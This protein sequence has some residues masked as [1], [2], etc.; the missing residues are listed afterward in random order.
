MSRSEQFNLVEGNIQQVIVR[1]IV[2]RLTLLMTMVERSLAAM[3]T[4]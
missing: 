2:W 1:E 3:M 4:P